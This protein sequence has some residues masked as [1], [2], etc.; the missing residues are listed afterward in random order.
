MLSMSKYHGYMNP[1]HPIHTYPLRSPEYFKPGA[2]RLLQRLRRPCRRRILRLHAIRNR[3]PTRHAG[4]VPLRGQGRHMQSKE[5]HPLHHGAPHTWPHPRRWHRRPHC[6]GTSQ[7]RWGLIPNN[8][9]QHGPRTHT[10]MHAHTRVITDV[11]TAHAPTPVCPSTCVSF[12]SSFSV[13]VCR[14]YLLIHLLT[15]FCGPDLK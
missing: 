11:H 9:H 15:S 7:I 14:H 8:T 1:M 12:M 3:W 5:W 13:T 4:V 6:G 2:D 10:S